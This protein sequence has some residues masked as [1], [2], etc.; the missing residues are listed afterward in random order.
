M[1][2]TLSPAEDGYRLIQ[3][4]NVARAAAWGPMFMDI[5]VSSELAGALA[6]WSGIE[7]G[8]DPRAVSRLGERGLLQAMPNTARAIF[9]GGEIA[10]L[11][12][13]ATTNERHAQLALKEY[14][15]LWGSAAKR[16][17]SPPTDDEGKAFFAKL[18][19]QRPKDFWDVKMHGPALQMA[20][21][22][23]QLWSNQPN[24]MHRLRAASVVAWASP[25]PWGVA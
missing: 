2:T 25:S 15:W 18:Y 16:V 19:H 11:A 17:S 20:G 14:N 12:N 10:E 7:S 13:P 1:T 4:A 8:G 22:L 23:A 3:R 5:G 9:T 6:R 24:A 21:E